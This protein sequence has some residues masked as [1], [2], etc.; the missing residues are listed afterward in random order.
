M[1]DRRLE[2]EQGIG[3]ATRYV[4][5]AVEGHRGGSLHRVGVARAETEADCFEYHGQARGVEH[6]V[7]TERRGEHV[8]Y[9]LE[10]HGRARNVR[11]ATEQEALDDAI[12]GSH[13]LQGVVLVYGSVQQQNAQEIEQREGLCIGERRE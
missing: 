2:S 1:H 5:R 13:V 9:D 7:G 3:V 6:D 11:E 12:D 4:Q 10:R 8:A